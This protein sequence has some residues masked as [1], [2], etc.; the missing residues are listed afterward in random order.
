MC[1]QLV[2]LIIST[3][4]KK[5]GQRY[6]CVLVRCFFRLFFHNFRCCCYSR[7]NKRGKHTMFFTNRLVN[8]KKMWQIICFCFFG[9]YRGWLSMLSFSVF[10][11]NSREYMYLNYLKSLKLWN[12][13]CCEISKSNFLKCMLCSMVKFIYVHCTYYTIDFRLCHTSYKTCKLKFVKFEVD[14]SPMK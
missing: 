3:V 7:T 11:P 1:R 9:S 12:K 4:V 2:I 6:M 10:S 5:R 14:T 13:F 8:N